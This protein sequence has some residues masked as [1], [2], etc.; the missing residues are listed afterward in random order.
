MKHFALTALALIGLSSPAAQAGQVS[1]SIEGKSYTASLPDGLQLELLSSELQ[2]P[3]F[4][5]FSSQGDLIV[6]SQAGLIYRLK[7]PYTKAEVLADFGGYPHSVAFRATERG[8]ELWVAETSGLYRTIYRPERRYERS[9]FVRVSALPGGNGHTS[10]TVSVGPDQRVY[11]AIGIRGNCSDEFLGENYPFDL[12]RG[13]IYVLDESSGQLAL[14]PFAS[15]LRN[16]V[17]LA[18]NPE[19]GT[20]YASN[21]GPDHL[22]FEQPEEV[23]VAVNEGDFFG[24]PWYQTIDGKV[25]RDN[26]IKSEAPFPASAVKTAQA[27]LPSRSAPLGV[28]FAGEKDLG[29]R[30]TG[31]AFIAVHGSW[32]TPPS[33]SILGNNAGRRVPRIALVSPSENLSEARD[34]DFVFG[35]QDSQGARW[36][37]PAGIAFGPDG[38]LYF[39][40]DAGQEGL[41]R[42]VLSAP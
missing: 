38:A 3:R 1:L 11:V 15:G 41:Y 28:A 9:D 14:K 5:A 37:R 18:W 34:Q 31:Q 36:A 6:G 22:G 30:F 35:F 8:E 10:R 42:V 4:M 17:G 23:F 27:T 29:G 19:N 25:T 24:M 26:C 12:R 20:L 13:G 32:G 40:S 21:N 33:G 39:T 2:K 7:A 16:P